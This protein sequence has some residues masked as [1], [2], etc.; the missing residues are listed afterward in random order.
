MNF[1]RIS[2]II[3]AAVVVFSMTACSGKDEAEAPN[4]PVNFPVS[5]N[6]VTISEK[7]L[8]IGSMSPAITQTLIDLELS[9]RL[10][11]ISG[12]DAPL[13]DDENP[14]YGGY[15]PGDFGTVQLPD[16]MEMRR[17]RPDVILTQ[18]PFVEEDLVKIQ[19]LG[20][21]VVVLPSPTD[22]TSLLKN[23]N[24]IFRLYLGEITGAERYLEFESRFNAKVDFLKETS[25]SGSL[26]KSAI[27]MKDFPTM[28]ATGDTLEHTFL[29]MLGYSNAAEDYTNWVYPTDKLVDLNPDVILYSKDIP[30]ETITASANYKT[31]PAVTNDELIAIDPLVFEK[32]APSMIDYLTRLARDMYPDAFLQD[33][34]IE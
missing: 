7:P 22:L 33:E 21:E 2:T 25:S 4:E 28:M 3:V 34:P 19:Q 14:A 20:I 18:T 8:A 10:V 24:D 5:V 31:V 13:Y 15:Q 6:G 32:R 29:T 9:G 1:K 17:V 23:C 11:G 16:L 12:Y 27:Y 26:G 30:K